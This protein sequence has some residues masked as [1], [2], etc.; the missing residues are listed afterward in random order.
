MLSN[1]ERAQAAFE[2]PVPVTSKEGLQKNTIDP[3]KVADEFL[4]GLDLF[5]A[6]DVAQVVWSRGF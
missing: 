2:E 1:T 6:A 4:A 3:N 5:S